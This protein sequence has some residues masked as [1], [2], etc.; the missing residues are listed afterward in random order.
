[1]SER[2]VEQ[3]EASLFEKLERDLRTGR[4][5]IASYARQRDV[6]VGSPNF[7]DNILIPVFDVLRRV[8]GP[9]PDKSKE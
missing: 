7:I 9:E 5:D 6:E 4:V 1:M 3:I 2:T 8:N